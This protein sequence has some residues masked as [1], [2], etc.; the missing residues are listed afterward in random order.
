M[1]TNVSSFLAEIT[2][3]ATNNPNTINAYKTYKTQ[4]SVEIATQKM[5]DCLKLQLHNKSI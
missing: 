3:I 4:F 2:P 1:R 5:L